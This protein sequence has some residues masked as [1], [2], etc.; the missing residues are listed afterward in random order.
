M[1]NSLPQPNREELLQA[2]NL[3]IR[4]MAEGMRSLGDVVARAATALDQLADK[5]PHDT[6]EPP[7]APP[8]EAGAAGPPVGP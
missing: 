1:S 8:A 5:L 6:E 3:G 7:V 2:L 4:T